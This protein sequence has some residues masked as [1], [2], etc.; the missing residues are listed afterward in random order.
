MVGCP[1]MVGIF[2]IVS[3]LVLMAR[4]ASDDTQSRAGHRSAAF[5]YG[6]HDGWY[7]RRGM[8]GIAHI[9]RALSDL[10]ENLHGRGGQKGVGSMLQ[11]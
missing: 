2:I 9:G 5:G 11:W 7:S 6:S 1:N 8:S 10:A 4:S 3:V